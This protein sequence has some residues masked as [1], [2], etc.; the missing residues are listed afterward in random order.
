MR[1]NMATN[2]P[3][4]LYKNLKF[5]E[6]SEFYEVLNPPTILHV[7]YCLREP[8]MSHTGINMY[9]YCPPHLPKIVSKKP[10]VNLIGSSTSHQLKQWSLNWKSLTASKSHDLF[11]IF[12]LHKTKVN[13]KGKQGL[14]NST[15]GHAWSCKKSPTWNCN[16]RWRFIPYNKIPWKLKNVRLSI[17]SLN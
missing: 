3:H 6:L 1:S 13:Y 5:F 9:A 2:A 15:R 7:N 10:S 11:P 16:A 14:K 12:N 17:F 8:H 4:H